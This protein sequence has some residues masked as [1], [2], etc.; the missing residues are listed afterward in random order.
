[1]SHRFY[2]NTSNVK[3]IVGLFVT[4]VALSYAT[5][6]A[7]EIVEGTKTLIKKTAAKLESVVL[8]GG[9]QKV[10]IVY[11]D[12]TGRMYDSGQRTWK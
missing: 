3:A 10:A 12:S 8:H 1:M 7:V 6:N 4:T 11:Q 5:S 9:K 2:T